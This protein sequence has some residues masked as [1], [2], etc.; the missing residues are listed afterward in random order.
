MGTA[1]AVAE[2]VF[3]P[4]T[5]ANVYYF[6]VG[7]FDPAHLDDANALIATAVHD[8]Y[9]TAID[10]AILSDQ[11]RYDRTKVAFRDAPGSMFRTATVVGA[12]G[13]DTSGAEEGQVAL[14]INWSSNDP[15]RGGKPRQYISG[16]PEDGVADPARLDSTRYAACSGRLN[17]WLAGL[18]ARSHGT[19]SGLTLLEM[20]FRD[21]N[22]WRS[23]AAT[24]PIRAAACDV[25]IA[26]QRRRIDRLRH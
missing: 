26:T 1:K 16:V 14:L 4:T 18:N 25:T 19:A 15:R 5:W 24:W 12:A 9:V 10:L 6:A 11:W 23:A 2:G 20:S 22:A 17:T 8:L 21:S 7:T 13:T 3:G